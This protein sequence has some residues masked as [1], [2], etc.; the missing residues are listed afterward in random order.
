M[1][2]VLRLAEGGPE[3]EAQHPK[4]KWAKKLFIESSDSDDEDE[5]REEEEE[6]PEEEKGADEGEA[7]AATGIFA[8]PGGGWALPKPKLHPVVAALQRQCTRRLS[9]IH[10]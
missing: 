8:V 2:R 5:K 10:I 6:P 4:D 1:A 3:V 9:L 7:P